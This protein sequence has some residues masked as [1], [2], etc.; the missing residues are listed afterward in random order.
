[1]IALY[2]REAFVGQRAEIP[3]KSFKDRKIVISVEGKDTV[4]KKRICIRKPD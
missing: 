2:Y 1:M 3:K 4:A